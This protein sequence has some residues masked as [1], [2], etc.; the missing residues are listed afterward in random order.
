MGKPSGPPHVAPPTV[1]RRMQLQ[2][3]RDTGPEMLLRRTLYRMG[4]RYRIHVR[5]VPGLRCTVDILFPRPRVA[6]EV[7]GC[8]WHFCPTHGEIPKSNGAWW[9]AKL[10]TTRRRD[11]HTAELLRRHGWLVVTVWE[12]EGPLAAA[13]RVLSALRRRQPFAAS[14]R[15]T[16]P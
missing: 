2:A 13:K 5:P 9:R 8:F 1:R 11:A 10:L 4:L 12:H 16:S 6:V 14:H 7:R 15:K 3:E